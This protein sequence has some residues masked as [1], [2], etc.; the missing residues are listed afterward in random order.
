MTNEKQRNNTYCFGSM[1]VALEKSHNST[2]K[3]VGENTEIPHLPYRK[4]QVFG[5]PQFLVR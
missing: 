5:I 3:G 1:M 2:E 4:Y